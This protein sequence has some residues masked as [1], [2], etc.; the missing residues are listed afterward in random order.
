MSTFSI[1]EFLF[2][3]HILFTV[4]SGAWCP[5]VLLRWFKYLS[6]S[7]TSPVRYLVLMRNHGRGY[8]RWTRTLRT[9]NG[10][11][12]WF[13]FRRRCCCEYWCGRDR[14]RGYLRWIH[15]R[16]TEIVRRWKEMKPSREKQKFGRVWIRVASKVLRLCFKHPGSVWNKPTRLTLGC[17]LYPAHYFFVWKFLQFRYLCTRMYIIFN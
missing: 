8:R 10:R 7:I 13:L 17:P 9:M 2:C 16:G 12:R 6:M 3:L 4:T 11:N 5:F 15:E 1:G 14:S